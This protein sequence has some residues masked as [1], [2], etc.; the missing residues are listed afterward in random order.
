MVCYLIIKAMDTNKPALPENP[1]TPMV[2]D[3]MYVRRY[4]R[5]VLFV[6]G[7]VI[8]TVGSIGVNLV[9]MNWQNIAGLAF[10]AVHIAALWL[11]VYDAF[12]KDN[13]CGRVLFALR[14]FGVS[15]CL[16]L[17][18]FLYTVYTFYGG[19]MP[20]IPVILVS[21]GVL[22]VYVRYYFVSLLG[23]LRGLRLRLVT[24]KYVPMYGYLWFIG[25]SYVLIALETLPA[26]FAV[27]AADGAYFVIMKNVGLVLC[28]VT[29]NLYNGYVFKFKA[30]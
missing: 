24:K 5:S 12:R 14:M 25:I 2:G 30:I 29:L 10:A 20:S 27:T 4:T 1:L 28:L 9:E 13:E 23:V 19:E 11:L 22:Y 15:A 6:L 16:A 21:V 26:M 3:V 18:S 7:A 17:I 8:I